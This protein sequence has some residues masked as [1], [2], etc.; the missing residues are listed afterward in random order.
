MPSRPRRPVTGVL[1]AVL[2]ASSASVAPAA[3]TY[4]VRPVA[5]T[6][7]A[8]PGGGT[9]DR[10][11][12]ETLPIVAPVNAAGD[13]A[14]FATLSHGRADEGLFL[15]RGGR[16]LVVAREGDAVPGAGR[17]AGF[18]K[19][20][21]PAL[22]D[23]G[24]VVFAAEV[25][26]G[27]AVEGIFAWAA[28]RIRPIAVT[29]SRAPDMGS[30]VLAALDAPSVNAR[31][32]VVF[33]ATV[34][35]G[36]ESS[37]AILVSAGGALRKVV[38]QGDPAP[39]G[40]VFA[41]FGPPAVNARGDVAFGAVVEGKAVPGGIF[42]ARGDQ[43][44]QRQQMHQRQQI[45]QQIEMMVGAGEETPIGGIFAKFSERI[46][47]NDAGVIA[48]HGML[49]AAPVAAAIFA[50]DGGRVVPVARLGDPAP[51]G[52]TISQFG[53]WPTV[54]ASGA[55][56]F[57]ASV[58]NGPTSMAILLAGADGLR[59]VVAVGDA[60]PGTDRIASLTLFPVVSVGPRGQVTFA[61]APTATGEGPEGVFSAEPTLAH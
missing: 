15:R 16:L 40:G 3:E 50:V 41:A 28:G 45:H 18:G 11:G 30:S 34:R 25:T 49:K 46:S 48:F 24:T 36:R 42:V 57:A 26:G 58:E 5:R 55:I 43:I 44:G 61:V 33:L 59:R 56:A 47:F 23:P 37:D 31:G 39:A 35:R 10:F 51:G 13:V 32:D 27:R 17:L 53:L 20:P 38:A 7:D 4:M 19:H 8:A 6:G 29:G 2:V 21:T 1:L 54:S 60:L 52:G 14:F 12:Q 9:F 22:N